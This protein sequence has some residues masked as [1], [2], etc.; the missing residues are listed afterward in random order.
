MKGGPIALI[1]IGTIAVV[2][3]IG[4]VIWKVRNTKAVKYDSV[5]I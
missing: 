2:A 3:A 5:E 4:F 1:V